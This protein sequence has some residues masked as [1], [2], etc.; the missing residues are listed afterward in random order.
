V[1][2]V[3]GRQFL[4]QLL[5]RLAVRLADRRHVCLTVDVYGGIVTRLPGTPCLLPRDGVDPQEERHAVP[6]RPGRVV[7]VE[8]GWALTQ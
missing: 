8:M 3:E 5:G 4:A 6:S 2:R 1:A 7:P